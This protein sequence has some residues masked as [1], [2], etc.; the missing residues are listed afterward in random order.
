[1]D[2]ATIEKRIELLERAQKEYKIKKEM[3]TDALKSDEELIALEDK[4]K[5]GKQKVTALKQA[6]L[7]EPGNRKI[8]EDLKDLAQ[9]IKDTKAL[10][11]DELIGYFMANKTTEYVSP[12]GDKKRFKVS[13][14]FVKGKGEEE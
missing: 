14:A 12:N 3:L 8:Q 13:A 1:M 6:L 2:T 7:N 11:G 5:D 9:E 4:A 10:L